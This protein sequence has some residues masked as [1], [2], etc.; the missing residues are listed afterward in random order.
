MTLFHS[1]AGERVKE[2]ERERESEREACVYAIDASFIG[3]RKK[4]RASGA[5]ERSNKSDDYKEQQPPT[6]L[7]YKL[8]HYGFMYYH[9]AARAGRIKSIM[10]QFEVI[11]RPARAPL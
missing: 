11:I 2:K 8:V 10:Y 1:R 7:F 4:E 5:N 9:N 3:T 6:T